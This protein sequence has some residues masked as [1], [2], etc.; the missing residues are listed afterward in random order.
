MLNLHSYFSE[1]SL[2][3]PNLSCL[4]TT[5]RRSETD[6]GK[7]WRCVLVHHL[8]GDENKGVYAVYV[9]LIDAK[10]MVVQKPQAT[11]GWTWNQRDHPIKQGPSVAFDK[12]PPEP[13]C[14]LSVSHG[15]HI[16]I[17]I[18]GEYESDTIGNIDTEIKGVPPDP[19]TIYYNAYY[20]VF[21][22]LDATDSKTTDTLSDQLTL[23]S[24]DRRMVK[25]EAR[26]EVTP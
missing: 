3:Q 5:I 10:C 15:Q 8:T 22:L 6:T 21:M 14:Q 9:D 7:V 23:E 18:E 24:L 2:E 17:W 13:L 20:I 25:L 11:L 19:N 4:W 26:Q 16:N 12:Q 1:I